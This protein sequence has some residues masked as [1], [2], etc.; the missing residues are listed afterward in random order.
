MGIERLMGRYQS[1]GGRAGHPE[2]LTK[3]LA[4]GYATTVCSSRMPAKALR[5]NAVFMRRSGAAA[6]LPDAELL[7]GTT[8]PHSHF[9]RACE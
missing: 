3:A 9:G 7:T 5:E 1:G 6:G 2:M 8:K 4:H